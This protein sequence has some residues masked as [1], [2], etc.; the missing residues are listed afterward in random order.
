MNRSVQSLMDTLESTIASREKN[1]AHSDIEGSFRE[2]QTAVLRGL[3]LSESLFFDTQQRH[4]KPLSA[5]QLQVLTMGVAFRSM[6]SYAAIG[7]AVVQLQ[8]AGYYRWAA[9]INENL[10]DEVGDRTRRS[11]A[12]LLYDNFRI[13]ANRLGFT[14]IDPEVFLQI[15]ASFAGEA[16]GVIKQPGPADRQ[17]V[18]TYCGLADA[19]MARYHHE[20]GANLLQP[21]PVHGQ[22]LIHALEL[23][24]REAS[25]VDDFAAGKLSY[26][27]VYGRVTECLVEGLDLEERR[28]AIAWAQAHNDESTGRDAGWNGASE[29]GHAEDAKRLVAELIPQAT[30]AQLIHALKTVTHLTNLRGDHWAYVASLLTDLQQADS[31]QKQKLKT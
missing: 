4:L 10:K 18:E 19:R 22:A 24:V 23:A 13:V 20:V 12:E 27:G 21:P 25:S 14:P 1:R 3:P 16:C 28:S 26:I 6:S 2:L 31:T 5:R 15:A 8:T 7:M 11:H 17:T 30:D 9:I 29:E